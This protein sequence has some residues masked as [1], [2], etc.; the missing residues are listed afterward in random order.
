MSTDR[1][2]MLVTLLPERRRF[3]RLRLD[4]DIARL[5]GRG[6]RLPDGEV[7]E[8]AQ[9]A[10]HFQPV[11]NGWPMA[12]LQRQAD[13][14]DASGFRWLRA[15]PVHV[16]PDINGA[17]LMAW[18]NLDLDPAEAEA[19][20]QALHPVFG[21]AGMPLT[22]GAPERWYLQLAIDAPLPDFSPPEQG[23]G[24]DLFRHLPE[25]GQGRRWRA[26]LNEAQILLHNHPINAA[27]AARGRLPANSL[28][29]WGAGVV[30]EEVRS[31]LS[32]VSSSENDVLALATAAGIAVDGAGQG[33]RL[34]DLRRERDWRSVEGELS[35]AGRSEKFATHD[36][37][38][39][40]FADG[41]RWRLRPAQRWR[42]WRRP[43]L[44]L[45]A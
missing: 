19:L 45:G 34:L 7:G 11:P 9:L 29:F 15:D 38:V 12:A 44:E 25:G 40:D 33:D 4:A 43:M 35:L 36:S 21:D 18:G 16:R 13:C 37:I 17:R 42:F 5:L 20:L 27:R 22:A 32:S 39:L 23:L 1:G 8:Q 3:G 28:W 41:A 30:P 24:D 26:L 6:D 31:R 10:R 14:G 2:G